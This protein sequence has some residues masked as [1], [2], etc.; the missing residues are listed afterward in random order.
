MNESLKYVPAVLE[1]QTEDVL[2]SVFHA[3]DPFEHQL[4][5]T[6]END[7]IRL[8]QRWNHIQNLN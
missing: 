1:L 8:R 3:H 4:R 2:L 5:E 7:P 6:N